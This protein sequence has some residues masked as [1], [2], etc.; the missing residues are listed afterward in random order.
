MYRGGS[1]CQDVKASREV[2]SQR[3]DRELNRGGR[4][5]R[6]FAPQKTIRAIV[7][8]AGGPVPRPTGAPVDYQISPACICRKTDGYYLFSLRISRR[9][10][11]GTNEADA[12][13]AGPIMPVLDF[14]GP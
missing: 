13:F 2:L 3:A 6:P 10:F 14:S 11:S 9:G 5:S 12:P 7:R 4:A 1:A 8:P